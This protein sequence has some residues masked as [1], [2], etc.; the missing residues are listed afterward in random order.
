MEPETSAAW[1]VAAVI[2]A[3]ILIV[4]LAPI[5]V[6]RLLERLDDWRDR[7][8]ARRLRRFGGYR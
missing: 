6:A 3:V 5:G 8:R 1:I 2:A 7:R 4:A